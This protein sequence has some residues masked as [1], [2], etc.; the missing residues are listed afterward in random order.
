M[1]AEVDYGNKVYWYQDVKGADLDNE[2][3]PIQGSSNAERWFN[4]YL[5]P[6]MKIVRTETLSDGSYMV[7]F[8]DGSALRPDKNYSRDWYFYP[9]K[10]NKCIE[11]YGVS[12]GRQLGV[13]AFSFIFC[14]TCEGDG[15]KY[16]SRR[17]MDPYKVG[18]NGDMQMLYRGS[19]YSCENGNRLYCTAII[20]NNGWKIPDDFPHKVSY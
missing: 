20:Q 2:G 1:L 19:V 3:N 11:K 12:W 5:A 17:G 4:K 14:P 9:G 16:H 6:Y 13:C 15:W 10:P 7:Y 18:W 8:A